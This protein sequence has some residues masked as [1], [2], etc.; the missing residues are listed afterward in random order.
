MKRLDFAQNNGGNRGTW[1]RM[2][3]NGK[4]KIWPQ[5][6]TQHLHMCNGALDLGI[7]FHPFEQ[8]GQLELERSHA[9]GL[10]LVSKL[11][12]LRQRPCGGMV[13]AAHTARIDRAAQHLV[14]RHVHY[15]AAYVPQRLV[16]AGNGGSEDWPTTIK[17]ADIHELIEMLHLHGVAA[18]DQ[19]LEIHDA[20]HGSAGLH[21]ERSLTPARCSLVGL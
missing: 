11:T 14:H 2:E 18:D 16:D 21:F 6:L 19:V 3:V 9:S 1:P 8:I 12:S 17:A 13:V 5:A 7:G 10:R 15:L 4:I 20:S